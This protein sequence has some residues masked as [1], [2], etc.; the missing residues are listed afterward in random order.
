MKLSLSFS[1]EAQSVYR[2]SSV[3]CGFHSSLSYTIQHTRTLFPSIQ[4]VIMD[5]DSKTPPPI[6]QRQVVSNTNVPPPIPPRPAENSSSSTAVAPNKKVV[7]AM[8]PS[9]IA[10]YY[11]GKLETIWNQTR[12]T[13]KSDQRVFDKL[14]LHS[15]NRNVNADHVNRL[16][17][18]LLLTGG[19]AEADPLEITAGLLLDDYYASMN[20]PEIEC[21]LALLDGQHRFTAAKE[22]LAASAD[23]PG[24]R[25]FTFTVHLTLY[26]C[27]DESTLIQ[28]IERINC[29]RP[30]DPCDQEHVKVRKAFLEALHSII[31]EPNKRRQAIQALTRSAKLRDE[32]WTRRLQTRDRQWFTSKIKELSK[33]QSFVD[34]ARQLDPSK[35]RGKLVSSTGL[36][37]LADD[38]NSWLER[39]ADFPSTPVEPRRK[40][41]ARKFEE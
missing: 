10:K 11:F 23:T 13:I 40:A 39:L 3:Y 17:T 12:L 36:T 28:R 24:A 38:S 6:P 14:Y 19:H 9:A 2:F 26:I 18:S 16:K 1:R 29:Q 15:L 31:G 21:R 33:E 20:D 8:D 30:F 34:M 32:T 5:T 35:A 37:L 27:N 25:Q 7:P 41:K 4:F 22:M